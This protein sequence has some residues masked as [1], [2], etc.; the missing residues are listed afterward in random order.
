MC[1]LVFLQYFLQT[2][3]TVLSDSANDIQKDLRN[4]AKSLQLQFR[5]KSSQ[6]RCKMVAVQE[7]HTIC[8]KNFHIGGLIRNI[9]CGQNNN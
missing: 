9:T 6:P 2:L 4:L 1:N 7:W 5:I 8:H 3:V